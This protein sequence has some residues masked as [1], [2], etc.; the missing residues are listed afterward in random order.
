MMTPRALLVALV[1]ALVVV[2]FATAMPTD[3]DQVDVSPELQALLAKDKA[4]IDEERRAL[5][6]KHGQLEAV[7]QNQA[8]SY[9]VA[10]KLFWHSVSGNH[11]THTARALAGS[12]ARCTQRKPSCAGA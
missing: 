12:L 11:P 4:F 8:Y 9:A 3:T 7:K 2:A 5:E 1:A 10:T 6:G